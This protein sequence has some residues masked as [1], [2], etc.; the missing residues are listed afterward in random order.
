MGFRKMGLRQSGKN[1]VQNWNDIKGKMN[2]KL[3]SGKQP[4]LE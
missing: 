3:H 1:G 2:S 4:G